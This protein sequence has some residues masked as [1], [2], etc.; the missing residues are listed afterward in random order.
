[1]GR[2]TVRI[3]LDSAPLIYVVEGVAPFSDGVMTLLARPGIVQLCSELTRLECRVKPIRDGQGALLAAFDRYFANIIDTILPLTRPVIDQA[4]DLRAR[5]NF[6]TPDALH[7]AAAIAAGCDMFLTND[8]R[9][10]K[11]I[12]IKVETV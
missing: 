5:Y 4:T 6:N 8:R 1:M 10:A 9:L 12:E 11:C 2:L 3:Y 7:L